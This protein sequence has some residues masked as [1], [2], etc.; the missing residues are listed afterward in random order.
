M[1]LSVKEYKTMRRTG[2]S[3]SSLCTGALQSF[4]HQ[5]QWEWQP[6]ASLNPTRAQPSPETS[7]HLILLNSVTL[8]RRI[9]YLK[10]SSEVN[11]IPRKVCLQ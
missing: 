7:H 8:K 11:G 3:P 2:E 6:K 4:I 1:H 9:W 10:S 5:K